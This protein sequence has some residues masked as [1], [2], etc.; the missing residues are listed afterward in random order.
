[1]SWSII[2]N[3]LA[4]WLKTNYQTFFLHTLSIN[5]DP[6][7]T[8]LGHWIAPNLEE[9]RYKLTILRIVSTRLYLLSLHPVEVLH[10]PLS[11]I[12]LVPQGSLSSPVLLSTLTV[13]FALGR[14]FYY[15]CLKIKKLAL[16]ENLHLFGSIGLY[17]RRNSGKCHLFEPVYFLDWSSEWV[18][19]WVL[20]FII[21]YNS[22]LL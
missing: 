1:M 11:S 3:Q 4:L 16:S 8:E 14:F 15:R 5:H 21:F 18:I 13:F 22:S 20:H 12:S 17:H 2:Q 9:F 6:V 10:S 19:H 7:F